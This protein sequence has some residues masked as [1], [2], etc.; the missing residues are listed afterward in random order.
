MLKRR[1]IYREYPSEGEPRW[2]PLMMLEKAWQVM[3]NGG[4]Q[5]R[6][7]ASTLIAWF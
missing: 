7:K 3:I 4:N 5:P 2:A 6:Q 1:R